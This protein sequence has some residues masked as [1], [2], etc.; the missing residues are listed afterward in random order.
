MNLQSQLARLSTYV[1]DKGICTADS[2][3]GNSI[4]DFEPF[5]FESSINNAN[6]KVKVQ[7]SLEEVDIGLDNMR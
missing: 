2:A 3:L 7:D 4:Y 6:K 5:R 1:A